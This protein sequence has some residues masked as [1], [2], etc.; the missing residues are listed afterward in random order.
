M[1]KNII[2]KRISIRTFR[3]KFLNLILHTA[4]FENMFL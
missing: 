3:S 4:H 1:F 2:E